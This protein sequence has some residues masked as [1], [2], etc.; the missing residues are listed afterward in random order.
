MVCDGRVV[1]ALG[2]VVLLAWPL[3]DEAARELIDS[4]D[5]PKCRNLSPRDLVG[6][7]AC[8]GRPNRWPDAP[9][10]GPARFRSI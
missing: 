3:V 10:P 9:S 2:L 1:V 4:P 6:G 5:G 7:P 8:S